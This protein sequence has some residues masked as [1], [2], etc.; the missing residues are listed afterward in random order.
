MPD[1]GD[2]IAEALGRFQRAGCS[3]GV[4]AFAAVDGSG[5]VVWQVDGR[6]GEN[7]IRTE[8]ATEGEAWTGALGQARSLGMLGREREPGGRVRG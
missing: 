3:V 6:N 7:L 4:A 5:R 1:Q 8:R 2:P